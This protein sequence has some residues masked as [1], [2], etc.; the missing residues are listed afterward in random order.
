MNIKNLPINKMNPIF[1]DL[2]ATQVFFFMN[3]NDPWMVTADGDAVNLVT[4]EFNSY[5]E[6]DTP[7]I[8]CNNVSLVFGE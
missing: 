3:D 5:V 6:S 7:V 2:T 8:P 4:G 1:D